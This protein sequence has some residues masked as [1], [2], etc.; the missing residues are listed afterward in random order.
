MNVS[1]ARSFVVL[2]LAAICGHPALLAATASSSSG[3][4]PLW[5]VSSATN[6]IYLLGSIHVLRKTDY[7][8]PDVI[9]TTFSNAPVATFEADIDEMQNPAVAI[10][11][12][13]KCMLP[14]GETLADRLSPE[15]YKA[16]TNKVNEVSKSLTNQAS[17]SAM[18]L[19]MID[20]FTP[21]MAA[22]TLATVQLEKLHLDPK[23]GLDKK[24]YDRAKKDGKKTTALETVEFQM[25]LFTQLT[26]EEGELFLKT[27]LADMDKLETELPEFI[28]AWKNG[29]PAQLEKL[30]DEATEQA[31]GLY[32]R[33]ISDRNARWVP[34]IEDLMK[35]NKNA[36]VIVGTGHL[37]GKDNVVQL[38]EKKGYKVTQL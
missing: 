14:E 37:V 6:S 26:K 23:Y 33:L 21:G 27:A 15:L 8:L 1:K 35:E 19:M 4:H 18:A 31:P 36:I 30:L 9:E 17:E 11:M 32:K 10:Q 2:C 16:F 22:T 25:D 3:K 12:L 24:L 34:K 28:K 13:T 7:P 20:R 38:L 5:K 29:D